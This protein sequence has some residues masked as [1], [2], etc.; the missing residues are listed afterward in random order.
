[1]LGKTARIL[2]RAASTRLKPSQV[3]RLS[4]KQQ[5]VVYDFRQQDGDGVSQAVIVQLAGRCSPAQ[6]LFTM[7]LTDANRMMIQNSAFHI[8][9]IFWNAIYTMNMVEKTYSSMPLMA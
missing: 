2:H 5:D 4:S 9:L 6:K 3:S 7:A 8:G 1:M